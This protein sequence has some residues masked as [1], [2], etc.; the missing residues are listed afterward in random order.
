MAFSGQFLASAILPLERNS[1]PN[2]AGWAKLTSGPLCGRKDYTPSGIEPAAFPLLAQWLNQ[3]RHHVCLAS[4]Y[5]D[6]PF[7]AQTAMSQGMLILPLILV[8]KQ[9]NAQNLVL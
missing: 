6:Y 1:F 3:Q 8:I 5:T 7:R 4:L 2:K 9:L